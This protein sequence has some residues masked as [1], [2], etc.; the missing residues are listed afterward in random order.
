MADPDSRRLES[1]PVFEWSRTHDGIIHT[2]GHASVDV[3]T[4]RPD[5]GTFEHE[6]RTTLDNLRRTLEK[7]GSGM[8]KVL[9]VTVYLTDMSDYAALNKLYAAAFSQ[10]VPARTCVEVS[11][12]PYN[13]RV[14]IE[15]VAHT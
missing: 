15:A 2:S 4:L 13:F 10:P 1:G 9:K 7:A 5:P 8:D 14:E 6:L 3:D 12:L 11:R